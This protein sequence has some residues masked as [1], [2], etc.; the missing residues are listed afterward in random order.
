M[1]IGNGGRAFPQPF[2]PRAFEKAMVFI[3]GSNLLA[4][5]RSENI[6]IYD[7]YSI[8]EAVCQ[9]REL[10]RVYFYTS[11]DKLEKA[12]KVHG[13]NAFSNCRVILGHT[14]ERGDG[15]KKEKGVDALLVADIVYHAAMKNC[16]YAVVFSN[17]TDFVFAIKRVEDFGCKTAVVSTFRT[18]SE[19]LINTCDDYSHLDKDTIIKRGWGDEI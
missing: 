6:K 15:S 3:D 17:D 9:E 4:S 19:R 8:A 12:K 10:L 5:L 7:F 2:P 1:I 11:E 14:V 18:A 16:Q 13:E